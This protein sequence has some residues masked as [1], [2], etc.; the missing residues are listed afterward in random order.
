[1]KPE[2]RAPREITYRI[3]WKRGTIV[4]SGQGPPAAASGHSPDMS[5]IRESRMQR[6]NLSYL[7]R[8][9]PSPGHRPLQVAVFAMPVLLFALFLWMVYE[10][11]RHA[12]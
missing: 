10:L 12:R 5:I 9:A 3:G 11:A 4:P 7:W 1:M 6:W 8:R 2:D